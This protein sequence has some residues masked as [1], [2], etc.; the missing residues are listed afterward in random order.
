MVATI[1][2]KPQTKDVDVGVVTHFGAMTGEDGQWQQV[3]LTGK[4]KVAFD[5][6]MKKDT[7]FEAKHA[8][9]RNMSKLPIIDMPF[10]FDP[11]VEVRPS[12]KH[13]T[14]QQFLEILY[15]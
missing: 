14:L 15:C 6:V 10:A 8:I 11:S 2:A 13:G 9:G 5:I 1:Q 12:R 3:Q 4:K 7:F